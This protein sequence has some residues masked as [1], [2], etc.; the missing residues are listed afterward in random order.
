MDKRIKIILWVLFVIIW[1]IAVIIGWKKASLENIASDPGN[2]IYTEN[3]VSSAEEGA[4][5]LQPKPLLFQLDQRTFEPFKYSMKINSMGENLTIINQKGNQLE[6]SQ[7]DRIAFSFFSL[8]VLDHDLRD[9][10]SLKKAVK[11]PIEKEP[12]EEHYRGMVEPGDIENE[13]KEDQEQGVPDQG[14]AEEKKKVSQTNV[15][16]GQPQIYTN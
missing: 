4:E 5:L 16:G 1:I 13:G 7:S 12:D 14:A 3:G 15:K 2:I 11:F 6:P 10:D 8:G 9:E